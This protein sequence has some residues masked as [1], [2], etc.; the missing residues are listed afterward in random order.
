[1][2]KKGI[3][4]IALVI[5]ILVMIILGAITISSVKGIIN[6][7]RENGY[8]TIS[9]ILREEI[10]NVYKEIVANKEHGQSF[11]DAL[12]IKYAAFDSIV[13]IPENTV[14]DEAFEIVRARLDNKFTLD[15]LKN[16]DY[17][18][19]NT[20]STKRILNID[21]SKFDFYV[22][23]EEN[24]AFSM[25]P[26]IK[27]IDNIY[28]LE[29]LDPNFKIYSRI[30]DSS[31]LNIGDTV[32]YDPT[33]GVTD[34]TI[35]SYT[36]PIG[37]ALAGENES[38]NG[39]STQTFTATTSD[40]KWIVMGYKGGQLKLM[41]KELKASFTL[42]GGR[43]YLF[44]E[45]QLHKICK[46]YG[47]GT[48]ADKSLVTQYQ[49][50]NPNIIGELRTKTLTGS[51]ARSMTRKDLQEINNIRI[52]NPGSI[53]ILSGPVY[54]PTL[55]GIDENGKCSDENKKSEVISTNNLVQKSVFISNIKDKYQALENSIFFETQEYWT[56]SRTIVG[57]ITPQQDNLVEAMFN[58]SKVSPNAVNVS[59]LCY[60]SISGHFNN[61]MVTNGVRPVV[62]L[63]SSV[64]FKEKNA[65]NEWELIQE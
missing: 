51:G 2:K 26:Y 22:N 6:N 18:E 1:M 63:E 60:P 13:K 58:M 15:E 43:G 65:D 21:N 31:F 32:I 7:A 27:G 16:L 28:T 57:M 35:L 42:Y 38:G 52:I 30:Y 4:M 17:Y 50:G 41:S 55:N 40:N 25:Q 53:L 19:I 33:K 36:S 47:Y 46:I 45:E 48:G 11:P 44:G 9:R 5:T 64:L 8:E 29:Q 37:S 10:D 56:A 24:L 23:F 54:I 61:W 62:F 49:I 3:T 59:F 39:Y 12:I 20:L 34:T 14:S